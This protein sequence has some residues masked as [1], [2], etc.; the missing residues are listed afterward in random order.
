MPF[1]SGGAPP[2]K[3]PG[4]IPDDPVGLKCFGLHVFTLL[5]T[6]FPI[7]LGFLKLKKNISLTITGHNM[8]TSQFLQNSQISRF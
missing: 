4:C 1:L 7:R 6:C 3:K 2:K 8:Y 5:D